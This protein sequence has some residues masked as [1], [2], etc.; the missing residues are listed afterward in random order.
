MSLAAGAAGVELSVSDHGIGIPAS[1]KERLFSE[2]FRAS[3]ARLFTES[4]T[5]LG[6]AIVKSIVEGAGGTLAVDSA[7]GEGTTVRVSLPRAG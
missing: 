4:G 6:L 2:F 5:G 1:E 7:E 3:N